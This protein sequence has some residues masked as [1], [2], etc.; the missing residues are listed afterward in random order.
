MQVSAGVRQT[1]VTAEL[2]TV[3]QTLLLEIH[4]IIASTA[5]Q[6]VAGVGASQTSGSLNYPPNAELSAQE[7]DV[8]GLGTFGCRA[9]STDQGCRGRMRERVLR[10]LRA[11]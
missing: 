6:A 7:R 9:G 11:D 2:P 10:V 3:R 4:R 5:S 1:S 8:A